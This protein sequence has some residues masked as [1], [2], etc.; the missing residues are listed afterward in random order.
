MEK[1]VVKTETKSLPLSKELAGKIADALG[2]TQDAYRIEIVFD[3]RTK[4]QCF[5]MI[6]YSNV[7]NEQGELVLEAITGE[8]AAAA[9]EN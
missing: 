3:W 2:V 8:N 5:K 7:T 6:V 4:E 1:Q 9:K